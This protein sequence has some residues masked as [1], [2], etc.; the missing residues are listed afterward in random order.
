MEAMVNESLRAAFKGRT[1]LVTGH[2][3]FKGAWLSLWLAELGGRV[4]GLALDPD[5]QGSLYELLDPATFVRDERCDI[6]DARKLASIVS[7][8]Q[9][10]FVFHLAAQPL[11]RSSFDRPLET[12]EVNVLGS[13][14]V[15]EAVRCLE[16]RCHTI[17]VTSD[18]CYAN[19]EWFYAYRETDRLGGKDPYSMSKAAAELV[20]DCW[21][22]SFFSGH[23]FGSQVVSV[24]AGNVIG[25]GDHSMDRIIPDCVRAVTGGTKLSVRSPGS[26]RPWQHVLDCLHGYLTA[27]ASLSTSVAGSP[28]DVFNFGPQGG[29]SR[30]V[31]EVVQNFYRLWGA[32]PDGIQVAESADRKPEARFLAV[33]IEKA[34]RVLGWQPTWDFSDTL[35]K[36]V[37][38]Y[39]ARYAG[40]QNMHEFSVGQIRDFEASAAAMR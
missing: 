34:Q 37:D 30:P 17:F 8:V 7:A 29:P 19:K 2:T 40:G 36:T 5:P 1:V 4:H 35:V 12:L 6:R 16:K 20:A 22:Q 14:H 24:R 31:L 3:G 15:L 28:G 32:L 27:A 9:P 10:D 21:R 26:T 38:W 39:R 33:S 25:G 13:A 23:V 18:K 11:V